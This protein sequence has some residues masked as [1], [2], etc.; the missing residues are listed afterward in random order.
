VLKRVSAGG[1]PWT[2]L[3]ESAA[4]SR[5]LRRAGGSLDV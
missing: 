3:E 2:G 1:D 4:G 5:L